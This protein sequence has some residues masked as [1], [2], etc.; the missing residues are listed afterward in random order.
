M[1]GRG[2]RARNNRW[3]KGATRDANM[4]VWEKRKSL[5]KEERMISESEVG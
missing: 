1:G 2:E 3:G 5:Q 4:S